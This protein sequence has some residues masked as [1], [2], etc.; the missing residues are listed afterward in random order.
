MTT[1]S[2]SGKGGREV[3]VLCLGVAVREILEPRVPYYS[4]T[5]GGC[6]VVAAMEKGCQ[7]WSSLVVRTGF[8]LDCRF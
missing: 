1:R 8:I 4:M 3:D 2:T 5:Q 7:P 6:T